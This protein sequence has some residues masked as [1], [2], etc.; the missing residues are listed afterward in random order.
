MN[1][2][3]CVEQ[4]AAELTTEQLNTWI[5]PLQ[6]EET[7]QSILLFAPNRF[8]KDWVTDRYL[9]RIQS[10]YSQHVGGTF[11]V[12]VR[13]GSSGLMAGAMDRVVEV[14]KKSVQINHQPVSQPKVREPAVVEGSIKH[15]NRLNADF[16]FENF[17]EGKSNQLARAAAQRVS[18]KPGSEYNPLFLYGDTGLG[19]THLMHAVGNQIRSYNP[20]AK[21]IYV[22]SERFVADMVKA[23]QVNAIADFKRVYR[24]VDALLIDDIQFFAGKEK[25]QEEFFHTFNSL[26]EGGQ[27]IILT[28]DRFPKEIDNMEDR[29]KSRFGWGLTV[30][31]E[32]PELETRVA[33]L[34]NKAQESGVELKRDCAFFIAQKVRSN[35][36]DLEGALKRVLANAHFFGQAITLDF[37][38]ETLRDLIAV[39]DR[40]ISVDNIQRMVADYFK[41]KISDLLSK[42]RNRS[43]ARPRQ[44]AMA[45]CKEL[46]DHSLPE[47]GDA[48][49]GRDHTT[50]LHACRKIK[51]LSDTDLAI[52]DDYNNLLK[53]LTG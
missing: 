17:V 14:P 5:K 21:I 39:H 7:V 30:R 41:I 23:L 24:N 52:R 10:F 53:A 31:L 28:S 25:S 19:K 1:W 37:V 49:G 33:I 35:V 36:R 8:V 47:I 6:V 45:L 51:E 3:I 29:L 11:Q 12:T 42:R 20:N 18:E 15:S 38:R 16:R 46:T 2:D 27:Q 40:Q 43:V 44:V 32:P 9:D 26:L 34:I 22:H 48:F 4:L 50:V 13:V